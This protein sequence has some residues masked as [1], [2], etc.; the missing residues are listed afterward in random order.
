MILTCTFFVTCGT[1]KEIEATVPE[2]RYSS[3]ALD[4]KKP[5]FLDI[6]DFYL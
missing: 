6:M 4:D 2:S 3:D 5:F 1:E